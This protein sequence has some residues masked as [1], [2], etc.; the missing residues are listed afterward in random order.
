MG[1]DIKKL[2][3]QLPTSHM[4]LTPKTPDERSTLTML[5]AINGMMLDM[6]AAIARKDY[7]DRR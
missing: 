3:Q 4:A 5:K 1:H 7:S 2:A 6:L